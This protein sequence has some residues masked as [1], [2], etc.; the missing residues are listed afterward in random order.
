MTAPHEGAVGDARQ[1]H[2]SHDNLPP[3]EEVNAMLAG[4][5]PAP[6]A[7]A[8]TLE[9]A[10][11]LVGDDIEFWMSN[12]FLTEQMR[13]DKVLFWLSRISADRSSADYTRR[14]QAEASA[15]GRSE[16]LSVAA[17]ILQRIVGYWEGRPLTHHGDHIHA[18]LVD[19][20]RAIEA[21][22]EHNRADRIENEGAQ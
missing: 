2:D 6:Q 15:Q 19:A 10:N 16:A 8:L 12:P 7:A 9:A 4:E 20:L 17:A 14:I 22:A 3:M 13:L 5:P 21:D 18:D 11:E 1:R